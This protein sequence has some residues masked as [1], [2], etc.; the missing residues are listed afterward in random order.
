LEEVEMDES[1]AAVADRSKNDGSLSIAVITAF[2][3]ES[4]ERRIL[5]FLQD[6]FWEKSVGKDIA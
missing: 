5:K 1:A 2:A 4:T 6:G 3:Q